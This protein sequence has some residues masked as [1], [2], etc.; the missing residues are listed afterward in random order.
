[1]SCDYFRKICQ[2]VAF[3]AGVKFHPHIARH[4][5]TPEILK[6]GVSIP[7]VSRLLGHEDLDFMSIYPHPSQGEA[8]NGA[9]KALDPPECDETALYGPTGN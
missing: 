7:Y 5:Y 3:T 4:T 6:R 1:M 2:D 8:I 9:R